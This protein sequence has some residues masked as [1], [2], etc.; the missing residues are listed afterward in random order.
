MKR[1]KVFVALLLILFVASLLFNGLLF[2]KYYDQQSNKIEI[3][4]ALIMNEFS[5]RTK[6]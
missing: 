3:E 2:K 4:K 1:T 5:E 6:D